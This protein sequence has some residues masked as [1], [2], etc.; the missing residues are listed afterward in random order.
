VGFMCVVGLVSL[1]QIP[2]L[3]WEPTIFF[4]FRASSPQ[5]AA[6]ET[7]ISRE[8]RSCL[9]AIVDQHRHE[10]YADKASAWYVRWFGSAPG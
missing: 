9:E 10:G 4:H 6:P 1:R 7:T 5:W 3:R 2:A 8:E